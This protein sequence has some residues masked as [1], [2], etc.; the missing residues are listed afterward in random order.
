MHVR[1]DWTREEIQKL[2]DQPFLDLVFEAQRVH[3]EHFPANTIQVSTLL[4][5]KRV[6]ALKTVNTV[7]SL[8]IMI[9]N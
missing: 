7:L 2:Y 8:H 6:N 1:N 9:L 3:R 5:I 4:S